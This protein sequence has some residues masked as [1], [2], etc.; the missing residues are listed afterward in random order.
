[1][2]LD[3]DRSPDNVRADLAAEAERTWGKDRA[4]ALR[5]ALETTATA[6]ARLAR[7]PLEPLEGEPAFIGPSFGGEG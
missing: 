2:R 1:M 7:A 6:L 3:Q 5:S 4:Q